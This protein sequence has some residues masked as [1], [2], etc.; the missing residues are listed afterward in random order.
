MTRTLLELGTLYEQQ[1]KLEQARD[2]WTLIIDTGL[3]GA[4]LAKDRLGRFNPAPTAP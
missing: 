2:A 4:S 1:A 3:P